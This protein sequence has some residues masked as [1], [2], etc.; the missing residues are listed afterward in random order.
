MLASACATLIPISA[1]AQEKEVSFYGSLRA[2]VETADH[3]NGDNFKDA[4]SR[5]GVTGSHDLGNG[6]TAFGTYELKV[7][8]A[9]GELGS[10]TSSDARVAKIGLSGDFGTVQVGRMWSAFYNAIGYAGDQLWWNSA[11]AYYTI[12]YN[13]NDFETTHRIGKAIMYTTPDLNGF[14]ASAL[15]SDD[16]EQGQLTASYKASDSLTLTAGIIDDRH[17]DAVGVAAYYSGN[18]FY[19]NGM[20][21]DKDNV[22]KGVDLIGGIPSGKNL[23]TLGLSSFKEQDEGHDIGGD[24]DAVILAYQHS[25]HPSLKLWAEFWA[26]D[27]SLYGVQDSNSLNLGI[28]Y[29][30]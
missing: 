24:F 30:F 19:L 17:D 21:I 23:Y 15:Y 25:I 13:W 5:I 2:M 8:V 4:L 26:W 11:P 18:G 9:E 16:Q 1:I 22:G 28:N 12:D 29:D 7:D 3:E 10:E 6:L 27:G 14:Q 20:F